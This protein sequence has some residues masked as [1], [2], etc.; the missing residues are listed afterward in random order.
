MI[1]ILLMFELMWLLISIVVEFVLLSVS[2][3]CVVVVC[4]FCLSCIGIS[5]FVVVVLL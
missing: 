2:V 5:L 4:R 3:E 1:L